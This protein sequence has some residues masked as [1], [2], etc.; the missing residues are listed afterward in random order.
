LDNGA[1]FDEKRDVAEL[2]LQAMGQMGYDALNMG[3][4]EL[5]FGKE[6]LEQTRVPFPYIASNLL[7]GGG[8]LPWMREYMIKEV[9]G[10]KVALLG[11]LDPDDLKDRDD[12]KGFEVIEPKVALDKLLPEVRGKADLVIL[13]GQLGEIK[14]M[15]LVEAVPGIDVAIFADMNYIVKPPEKN[16]ILLLNTEKGGALGL[17][18]ITLDD[19]RRLSVSERRD[20][21]MDSSVPDN[22]KML[23]FVETHKREQWLKENKEKLEV[24]KLTPQEFMKRNR[25]EQTN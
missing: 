25:Q 17:L 2:H 10:I 23:G 4:P 9:G 14:T 11:V 6:F 21:P 20:V 19:Q 12:L 18:T 8:R 13:M 3:T 1:V 22:K 15:A 7:Y 5:H 24:L 16:T